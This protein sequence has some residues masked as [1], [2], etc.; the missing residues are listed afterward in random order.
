MDQLE[1]YLPN[2]TKIYEE[3]IDLAQRDYQTRL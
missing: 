3:N 1:M 2:S